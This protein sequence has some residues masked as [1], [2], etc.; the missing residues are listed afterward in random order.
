MSEISD[1]IFCLSTFGFAATAFEPPLWTGSTT[2]PTAVRMGQFLSKPPTNESAPPHAARHSP[3]ERRSQ[4]RT[5][6]TP[7][8]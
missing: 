7:A 1:L 2:Q 4:A 8:T 5:D 6:S 3:P